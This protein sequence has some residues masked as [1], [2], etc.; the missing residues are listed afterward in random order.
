MTVSATTFYRIKV[1]NPK[2]IGEKV[3]Q[4]PWILTN[5]HHL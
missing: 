3:H 2:V 5:I 4:I 1:I